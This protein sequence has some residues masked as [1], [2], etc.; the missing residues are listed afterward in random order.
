MKTVTNYHDKPDASTDHDLSA[1]FANRLW[2][3]KTGKPTKVIIY[4][5]KTQ[6][7]VWA[8]LLTVCS[9]VEQKGQA[10][11]YYKKMYT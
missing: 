6:S 11:Q 3:R 10:T 5:L 1:S 8:V 7:L 4:H 9:Q 2:C